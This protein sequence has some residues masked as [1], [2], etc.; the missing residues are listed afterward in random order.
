[1]EGQEAPAESHKFHFKPVEI[2]ENLTTEQTCT[3]CHEDKD[4]TWVQAGI[5]RIRKE[6]FETGSQ[7][8]GA[9]DEKE[10]KRIVPL[11]R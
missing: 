7:A 10:E 9:V 4:Q 5:E 3:L 11:I 8:V 1:M 2:Q 6:G